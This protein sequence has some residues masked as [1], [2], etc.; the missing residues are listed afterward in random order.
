MRSV[1]LLL[2]LSAMVQ[3]QGV[4][5]TYAGTDFV[6]PDDGKPAVDAALITL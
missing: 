2:A 1:L 5:T 4:I 6:F 3:A